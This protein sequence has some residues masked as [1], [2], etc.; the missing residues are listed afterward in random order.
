MPLKY[1]EVFTLMPLGAGV[2]GVE[3]RRLEQWHRSMKTI[4]M[5]AKEMPY[6]S[7]IPPLGV[8]PKMGGQGDSDHESNRQKT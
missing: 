6:I 3:L 2:A 8:A 1:F 4:Q 7:P 5:R